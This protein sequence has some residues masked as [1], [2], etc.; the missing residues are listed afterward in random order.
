ML[1]IDNRGMR[2]RRMPRATRLL[3]VTANVVVPSCIYVNRL[4]GR[5]RPS[6]GATKGFKEPL[7]GSFWLRG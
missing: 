7:L 6:F 1:Q 3:V 2:M 5:G 4:N